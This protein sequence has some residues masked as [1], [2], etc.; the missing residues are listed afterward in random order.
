MNLGI[1]AETVL[2]VWSIIFAYLIYGF[3][4]DILSRIFAIM[5]WNDMLKKWGKRR[6]K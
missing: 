6:L 3:L 1:L 2:G 4:K 5:D